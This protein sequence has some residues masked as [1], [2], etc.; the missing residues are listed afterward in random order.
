MSQLTRFTGERVG[1]FALATNTKETAVNSQSMLEMLQRSEISNPPAYGAK[2]ASNVLR[3]ND[4]RQAWYAD[5]E[6]MSG[7]IRSMRQTLH[8]LL[9]S[10][11]RFRFRNSWILA[12]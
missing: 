8:D 7:R 5:L 4:L 11:G 12:F 9:V 1:C 3:T 6:T 10:Q 2:V